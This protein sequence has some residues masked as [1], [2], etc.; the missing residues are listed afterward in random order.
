MDIKII[1]AGPAGL[2]TGLKL[3]EAGFEPTIIEKQSEIVSKLCAEGLSKETLD[4]VPFGPWDKYAAHTFDHATLIFPSNQRAYLY[5]T[6][7][8]LDR[9][10]WQREM[11]SVFEKKGGKLILGKAVDEKN[12]RRLS[13]DLLVDA[14]GSLSWI[15]RKIVGNTL[16]IIPSVQYRMKTDYKY[17][18]MEFFIDKRFSRG[19][20]WVFMKGKTANVGI[21]GDLKQ[22]E[23]FVKAKKINGE[24]IK[25]EGAIISFSGT[26]S[27]KGNI[28]LTGDAAGITNPLTKGGMAACIFAAEIIAKAV[29]ENRISQYQSLL[30]AHPI[31]AKEYLCALEY[32]DA[33]KNEDLDDLGNIVNGAKYSFT[34]IRLLPRLI[35]FFLSHRKNSLA[36]LKAGLY[37]T[38]YSW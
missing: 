29:S 17:D 5:K 35:P 2:V 3:L 16:S 31:T 25:T 28:L 15:S 32:F 8:T 27:Q 1:G 14:S 11:A 36:A 6:A 24:I 18:G 9:T 33:L 10:S 34:S 22:L 37:C 13:Y 30:R 38:K 7:Y 20:S 21:L 19:Y 4:R 12:F 23:R 26:K